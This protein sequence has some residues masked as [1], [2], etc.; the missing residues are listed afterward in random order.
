MLFLEYITKQRFPV[1]DKFNRNNQIKPIGHA[2][3]EAINCKGESRGLY[4]A[5]M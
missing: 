4:V 1:L 3:H 5:A 2:T